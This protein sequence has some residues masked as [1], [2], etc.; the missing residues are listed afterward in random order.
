VSKLLDTNPSLNSNP[1]HQMRSI[2]YSNST[3]SFVL[4]NSNITYDINFL[5]SPNK[6]T[7]RNGHLKPLDLSLTGGNTTLPEGGLS[8][9]GQGSLVLHEDVKKKKKK[10]LKKR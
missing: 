6:G 2:I 1:S 5:Y 7:L 9:V 10:K 4:P 3:D 8:I